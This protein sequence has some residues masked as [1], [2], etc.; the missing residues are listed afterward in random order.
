VKWNG[1]EGKGVE[2]REREQEGRGGKGRERERE[3]V[4]PGFQTLNTSLGVK[5][6]YI[7]I[8]EVKSWGREWTDLLAV[9]IP[10]RK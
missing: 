1:G 4:V 8:F 7:I 9:D 5:S 2:R 10:L 6:V 3:K